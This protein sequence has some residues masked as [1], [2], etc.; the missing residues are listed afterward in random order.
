M[1]KNRKMNFRD[2]VNENKRQLLKDESY[3]EQL[4]KKIDERHTRNG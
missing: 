3:L 4:E 1:R 2:L